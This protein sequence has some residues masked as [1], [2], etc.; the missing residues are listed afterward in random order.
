MI[1]IAH[2]G[3]SA[4]FK[5]N[6]LQAF[7]AAFDMGALYMETDLQR[8]KDGALMLYHD[9]T[10]PNGEPIK[11]L[12]EREL[13]LKQAPSLKQLF[14]AAENQ[15]IKINIE[16]KNDNNIYPGIEKQLFAFL[17]L[18]PPERKEDLLISSFDFDTLKRVRALDRSVKIGV[19]TRNF[20]LAQALSLKAYS[21]NMSFK[22][23]TPEIIKTCKK[24]KIKTFIYTVNDYRSA[25]KLE[26][27]GADGIFSDYPEILNPNFLRLGLSI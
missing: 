17:K 14:R 20:N 15:K 27:M 11:N 2:R 1:T 3:A 13:S 8:S 25:L 23:I 18:L 26:K 7:K 4:Y 5:E 21:V 10:L 19:L 9:Y 22:R 6:T 12:S 16:I 24:N